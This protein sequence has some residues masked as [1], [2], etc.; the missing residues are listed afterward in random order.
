[1]DTENISKEIEEKEDWACNYIQINELTDMI[2]KFGRSTTLEL[3]IP[4]LGH[5]K[6]FV[7]RFQLY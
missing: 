6:I 7:G 2:N 4:N 3:K 1:M 5:K